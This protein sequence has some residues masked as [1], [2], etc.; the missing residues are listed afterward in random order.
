MVANMMFQLF[1]AFI[2]AGFTEAQALEL[3]KVQF[4][5]SLQQNMKEGGTTE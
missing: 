3:V 5:T 1:T 2:Q 4:V